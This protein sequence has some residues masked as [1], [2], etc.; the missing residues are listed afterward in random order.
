MPK[1][2]Q[3]AVGRAFWSGT[4]T[5]G[6]VSV[7]VDL[8]AAVRPRE[9]A[10]KMVDMKGR[11][12]GR[13]YFCPKDGRALDGDDLVRGFETEK[14]KLVVITDDELEAIAPEKSRDID[15]RQF[16]PLEQI[17]RV[18]FDRPYFLLPSGKS[19]KAYHLLAQTMERS[20]R[21]GIATFVMREK[22]YM[23]AIIAE[24]GVL[25]AETL[26][27]AAELRTPK[28]LG[29][30]HAKRPAAAAVKKFAKAIAGLKGDKLDVKEVS[31]WYA[32]EIQSLVQKTLKKKQDVVDM[33]VG[34][35]DEDGESQGAEV[36]D[37]MKIIKERLA[38][39]ASISSPVDALPPR[40]KA[41]P[42]SRAKS[43]GKKR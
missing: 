39:N 37:I 31:D 30:P 43:A 42:R 13:R 29:L 12:L 36:I 23:V 19:T 20:G 38:G 21:A 16:V 7:P 24:R 41:R 11:P 22:E 14:G 40:K 27:F 34:A 4:I 28:E 2:D 17:P 8:F 15:L 6:L 18:L 33:P 1:R 32:D 35:D 26:R 25:R 5:F 9:T 3:A 10:M